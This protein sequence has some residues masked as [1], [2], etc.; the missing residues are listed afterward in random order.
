MLHRKEALAMSIVTE[1]LERA[2]SAYKLCNH[3][4]VWRASDR[5]AELHVPQCQVVKAL[6]LAVDSGYAL[7]ILP[8]ARMLSVRSVRLATGCAT[9][10]L[11][12]EAEIHAFCAWCE[13]GAL[14][15][16]PDLLGVPGYVDPSV[17]D[18]SS[19]FLAAGMR[20]QS[21]ELDPAELYLGRPGVTVAALFE[22]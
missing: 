16:L 2:G 20:T 17:L 18:E 14:P 5:A 8:A 13:P 15:A 10:R 19:G 3:D 22:R 6:L 12:T 21:V 9:A 11:A 7:A 4:P 1:H